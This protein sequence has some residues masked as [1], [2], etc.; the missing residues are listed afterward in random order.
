[1]QWE[2]IFLLEKLIVNGPER[3]L[4]P[5]IVAWVKAK[6]GLPL[7][8]SPRLQYYHCTYSVRSVRTTGVESVGVGSE[9]TPTPTSCSVSSAR[10][11]I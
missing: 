4:Y 11:G 5:L 6:P 10:L 7:S 8:P 9:R 3:R 1:M 2:V